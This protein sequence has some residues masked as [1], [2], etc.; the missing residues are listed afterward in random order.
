MNLLDEVAEHL[1]GDVEVGD[2]AVAQRSDGGDVGRGTTDHPLRLHTDGE[3]SIV[4]RVDCND[5]RLVE[6]DSLSAHEHEGVGR[7]QV[8]GHVLTCKRKK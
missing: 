5:R 1:L 4:V 3:R 6:D 8:D 2:D 7:S